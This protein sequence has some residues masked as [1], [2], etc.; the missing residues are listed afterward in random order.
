MERKK[1]PVAEL[2]TRRFM[3]F[4]LGLI[5]SLGVILMAFEWKTPDYSGISLPAMHY[6]DGPEEIN[7]QLTRQQIEV[8]RVINTTLMR[9]TDNKDEQAV[10]LII[11]AGISLQEF[12]PE[13]VAP[14]LIEEPAVESEEPFIVVEDMPDFPGG[15]TALMQYLYNNI[16]YPA[17]ARENNITGTVY[18]TF[19]VEKDGSISGVAALREVS[20]GCTEEALRVIR[21]MPC[22]IPG[23]QRGIPVRVRVNIPVK[24][25]LL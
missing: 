22:W 19:V 11:E 8:P 24:F 12:V 23:K 21:S 13:F 3:M 14:E 7:I 4:Q 1:N 25:K 10:D 5:I 20:G 2:E 15:E 6:I 18:I 17:E 16:D 9:I